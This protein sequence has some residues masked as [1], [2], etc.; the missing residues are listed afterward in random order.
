MVARAASR[1]ARARGRGGRA[2]GRRDLRAGGPVATSCSRISTLGARPRPPTTRR[3]RWPARDPSGPT[4]PERPATTDGPP[5]PTSQQRQPGASPSPS[6]WRNVEGSKRVGEGGEA[7]HRLGRGVGEEIAAPVRHGRRR[8]RGTP[9]WRRGQ[10]V[11]RPD[12]A[13]EHVG[14]LGPSLLDQSGR[15]REVAVLARRLAAPAEDDHLDARRKRGQ[16][17]HEARVDG[18]EE[19]RERRLGRAT[20]LAAGGSAAARRAARR[21][22]RTRRPGRG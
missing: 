13:V 20:G 4:R 6:R 16:L 17:A 3:C 5:A 8:R 12:V 14:H 19:R 21:C 22:G 7:V 2:R 15:G 1:R 10:V 18:D 9:A 11:R